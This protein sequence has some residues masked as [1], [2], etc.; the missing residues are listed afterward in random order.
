VIEVLML[1]A[2]LGGIASFARGRGVSPVAAGAV[3]L[4]GYIVIRMAG[5]LVAITDDTTLVL[6]IAAWVWVGLVASFIR[7]V[8]GSRRPQPT[9]SWA[10]KDCLYSNGRHAVVCEACGQPWQDAD[11]PVTVAKT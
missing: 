6:A 11:A 4:V 9:R 10:C 3:A 2:A 8:I 7:F 5:R 1:A